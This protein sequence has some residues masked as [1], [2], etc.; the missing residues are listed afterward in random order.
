MAKA[1]LGFAHVGRKI[2]LVPELLPV[3]SNALLLKL[4][5]CWSGLGTFAEVALPRASF[6]P[7]Q[8]LPGAPRAYDA[9]RAG[10]ACLQALA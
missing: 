7:E 2:I 3:S 9:A 10:Q 8:R 5:R 1:K 4:G 6:W